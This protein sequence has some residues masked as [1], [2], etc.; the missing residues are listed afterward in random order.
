MQEILFNR[1]GELCILYVL[2]FTEPACRWRKLSLIVNASRARCF[3]SLIFPVSQRSFI[4]FCWLIR[5]K[6]W[7]ISFIIKWSNFL[8]VLFMCRC[9]K[10]TRCYRCFVIPGCSN[11]LTIVTIRVNFFGS[12]SVSRGFKLESNH[13]VSHPKISLSFYPNCL[14]TTLLLCMSCTN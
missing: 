11:L 4:Y 13:H 5:P 14:P 7:S 3:I 1:K 6:I 10:V 9:H 2:P 8:L 12:L